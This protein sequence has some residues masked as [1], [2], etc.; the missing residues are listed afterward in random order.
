MK[1]NIQVEVDWIDEGG[2]LDEEVKAQVIQGVVEKLSAGCL[3]DLTDKSMKQVQEKLDD[4]VV[5][6]FDGF[7]NKGI[8]LTDRWGDVKR[9]N[10]KVED[11]MKEKL[12]QALTEKVD[13]SGNSSSYGD[14]TRLNY[15]VNN[16]VK[17]AV[18]TMT[19]E[20]IGQVDKKIASTINEEVKQRLSES[21]L[22][23]INVDQ[24]IG[25][26]IKNLSNG[27]K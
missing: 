4:L 5:N 11:L 12:E 17:K 3:R 24:V 6:L 18:E 21:L 13:S 22:S 27:G 14:H 20:V 19:K 2:G 16:R 26:V 1:F 9:K 7:M 23:K 10:V 8:T 25:D 15:M